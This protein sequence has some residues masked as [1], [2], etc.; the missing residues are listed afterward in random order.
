METVRPKCSE[1]ANCR[2]RHKLQMNS[3][4]A[5]ARTG[6]RKYIISGFLRAMNACGLART[7]ARTHVYAIYFVIVY[8][9]FTGGLH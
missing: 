4:L 1:R 2:P 5:G 9:Q 3:A 8:C 7:H 6:V